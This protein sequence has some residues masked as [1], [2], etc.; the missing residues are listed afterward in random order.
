MYII[1][2]L[3]FQ[4]ALYMNHKALKLSIILTNLFLLLL[5][6]FAVSL[7]F[8]VTWYVETMGREPSLPTTIMVTCYPCAPFA[9][10]ILICI[11][12]LLKNALKGSVFNSLSINLMKKISTF[13]LIIA[14]ITL[15]AGKYYMPFF[16]VSGTF[17]FVSLLV[18]SFKNILDASSK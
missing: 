7:P 13:C 18:F 16:I 6:A 9:A 1:N 8:I 14:A 4:G 15:I 10:A 11:K 3:M 12:K 5:V 2:V 17:A